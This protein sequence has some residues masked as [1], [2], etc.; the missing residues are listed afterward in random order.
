ML[1]V[2]VAERLQSNVRTADLVTRIGGDEL[3]IVLD[4]VASVPE[5]LH[6]ANRLRLCLKSP[7][8][9][10]GIKF[11]VTASVG[12]AFC[13]AVSPEPPPKR[14][15]AT[16]IPHCTRRRTRRDAVAV[17][18]ESMRSRLSERVALEHDLYSAVS[19]GQLH[20]VYQ[21]IVRLPDGPCVGMEALVRWAHPTTASSDQ[22]NS[23]PWPKRPD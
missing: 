6:L 11:Y 1:L 19:L 17:F 22:P 20:L 7:F 15:C 16:P 8:L 21:P 23:S 5:A 12:L 4:R 18:D 9:L 2:Q 13:L 10:N 14:S 3:M